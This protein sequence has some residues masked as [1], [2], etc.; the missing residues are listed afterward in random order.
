MNAEGSGHSNPLFTLQ[1]EMPDVNLIRY[2]EGVV[3][4]A[5][6][7]EESTRVRRELDERPAYI[8]IVVF[9]GT[10]TFDAD[11]FEA[12]LHQHEHPERM[13]KVLVTVMAPG[14]MR[15]MVEHYFRTFPSFFE[16]FFFTDLPEAMPWV[17]ARMAARNL[18]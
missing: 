1:Q 14:P 8:T 6:L 3:I 13:T 10:V 4:N 12:D 15:D 7:V 9:P 2:K 18:S 16:V 11:L 17:E 5:A